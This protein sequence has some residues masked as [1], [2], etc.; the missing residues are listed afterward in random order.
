MNIPMIMNTVMIALTVVAGLAV[1]GC[2]VYG[3]FKGWKKG[4][5]AVIRAAVAALLAFAVT[6]LIFVFVSPEVLR[7]VFAPMIE[8]LLGSFGVT[9]VDA[10]ASLVAVLAVSGVVP[11]VFTALFV[12][13][14]L[15][16]ILPVFFIGRA[17]GIGVDPEKFAAKKQKKAEKRAAKAAKKAKGTNG[18]AVTADSAEPVEAA[19]TAESS[20][21]VEPAAAETAET[22]PA[23]ADTPADAEAQPAKAKKKKTKVP[24]PAWSRAVGATLRGLVAV[25]TV[26]L[27][28]MPLSGLVY[29]LTD[30]VDT[31]LSA[32]ADADIDVEIA[33]GETE[34]LGYRIA[35]GDGK[36]DYEGVESFFGDYTAPVCNN[37]MFRMSHFGPFGLTYDLMSAT[38][39]DGRTYSLGGELGQITDLLSASV[40]FLDD[41]G[42]YGDDQIRAIDILADY[43]SES[44]LH[45]RVGAELISQAARIVMENYSDEIVYGDHSTITAPVFELLSAMTADSISADVETVGEVCKIMIRYRVPYEVAVSMRDST[46]D[47]LKP[48]AGNDELIYELMCAIFHNEDC[49]HLVTP[50]VSYAFEQILVLFNVYDGVEVSDVAENMTDEDLKAE[51]VLLAKAFSNGLDALATFDELD[52]N[53]VMASLQRVDLVSLGRFIDSA[54]QS[55]LL[56]EGTHDAVVGILRSSKFNS[57]RSVAD[58]LLAHIEAGEDLNM[59]DLLTAVQQAVVLLDTYQ[60]GSGDTDMVAMTATLNGLIKSLNGSTAAIIK[61]IINDSTV[62]NSSMLSGKDG[63]ENKYTQ[64]LLSTMI[65]VMASEEFTE[66]EIE[67]EAKAVDYAMKLMKASTEKSEGEGGSVTEN[68]KDIYNDD[69]EGIEEM[70]ETIVESRLTTEAIK[71]VA[72]DDEGNLTTDVLE[73]TEKVGEEDV[74]QIKEKCKD[75]YVENASEKTEEEKEALRE[76]IKAIAALFGKDV[77]EEMTDWDRLAESK[78]TSDEGQS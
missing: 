65:D 66:E 19:E 3:V 49:R 37:V 14:D 68:I 10:T 71:A 50:G 22:Q 74:E 18:A 6:K 12:I 48:L 35:D 11:F 8:Q 5:L 15:I 53:D 17:F 46:Y 51:S 57:M 34:L 20:E 4:L 9:S 32:A 64:K 45:A 13:L 73:L 24:V 59:E 55:V 76:N 41:F 33:D 77:T 39:V 1:A 7:D 16:L 67:K 75:Y 29:N 60:N 30:C 61:E 27:V 69:P 52:G 23:A 38:R 40:C 36:L 25:V 43:I 28:L 26:A 70:V 2:I 47:N 63:G 78:D 54:E 56:G 62:L 42:E 44:E 72:Y 21:P 58:I 31:L